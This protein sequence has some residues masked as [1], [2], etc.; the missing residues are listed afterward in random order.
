MHEIVGASTFADSLGFAIDGLSGRCA[1]SPK[2]ARLSQ[3]TL[4][5]V[6]SR[7]W[8]LSGKQVERLL[9]HCTFACMG[10]RC[11]LSIFCSSYT[12]VRASYL[13]PVRVWRSVCKELRQFAYLTHFGFADLRRQ[14]DERVYV[15]DASLI[16]FG[17]LYGKVSKADAYELGS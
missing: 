2:K 12:F 14:W 16:G 9:G 5:R 8:P 6:A 3:S 11:L 17:V 10:R 7:R 15:Y 13:K 1:P 4:L